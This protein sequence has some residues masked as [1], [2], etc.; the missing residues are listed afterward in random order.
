MYG[1][2]VDDSTKVVDDST[3]MGLVE[4]STTCHLV[5]HANWLNVQQLDWGVVKGGGRGYI[6]IGV[7]LLCAIMIVFVL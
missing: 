3:I 1:N 7:F 6:Y 2:M 5:R 4:C